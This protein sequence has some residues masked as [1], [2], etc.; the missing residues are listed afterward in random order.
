MDA[1]KI[2][3]LFFILS[4]SSIAQ[5]QKIAV[6]F[7]D[8]KG[9]EFNPF[10]Y[11]HPAAIERRNNNAVPL[12][13]ESDFA[14]NP[15]YTKTVT[16]LCDSVKGE[17]RWLNAYFVYANQN[18]INL[19]KKLPFVQ[20]IVVLQSEVKAAQQNYVS[21]VEGAERLLESQTQFMQSDIF[22]NKSLT[23]KGVRI[24][25]FDT[26]FP[27]V[28]KSFAFEHIWKRNGIAGYYDFVKNKKNVFA[29]GD[30]GTMTLSCIAGKNGGDNIGLAIDADFLLA[31]TEKSLFEP[32]SEEENWLMAAEWADKNGAHIINSSL[33]Y[34]YHRYFQKNMDGKFSLVTK[35]ANMAAKKGIL[36]V[37]AA[38]NEGDGNWEIIGAP[39]DADSVLSVGGINPWTGLHTK[40]SSYGPTADG[41]L[42]P[43]VSALA[44]VIAA[45][46][47]NTLQEV[48]GTSFASPLTAGFAACV[49]QEFPRI[50]VMDLFKKIEQSG[51]LYPYYDYAHG[52][53]V[54]QASNVLGIRDSGPPTFKTEVENGKLKIII[55]DE[56]FVA[57]NFTYSLNFSPNWEEDHLE[58]EKYESAVSTM[59]LKNIPD[60][61]YWHVSRP[62]GKIDS[63]EVLM[64]EKPNV[65][66]LQ[67]NNF[68]GKTLRFHYK[69]YT[70][71]QNI[72]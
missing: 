48:Q 24:A 14:L 51:H 34:T 30:H 57:Q 36:V 39:A 41:R 47:K 45:N 44:W 71:I 17:S 59:V 53:G 25:V 19:I 55:L 4:L 72:E 69:G 8:K 16:N 10:T 27:N 26:G 3:F 7:T 21:L 18:Q 50:K 22:A 52:Y 15:N 13:H 37:N 12:I 28:D 23:G 61:F 54:P 1:F 38:G 31:R 29:Y 20:E 66:T 56:F 65:L 64:V 62:N 5:N 58:D 70:L 33:G 11:F 43:N 67:L 42:K 68:I 49:L 63:Y 35:A 46:K 60:Y 9:V 40:F 6:F 32:Y 2:I